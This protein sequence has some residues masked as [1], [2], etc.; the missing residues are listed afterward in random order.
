MHFFNVIE[1]N[2]QL[3]MMIVAPI[4][5]QKLQN[6]VNYMEQHFHDYGKT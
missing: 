6:I 2:G 3:D 5:Y 4:K 1:S